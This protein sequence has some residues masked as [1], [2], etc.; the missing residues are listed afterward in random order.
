MMRCAHC[1]GLMDKCILGD[2]V[3]YRCEDCY[4]GDP[5]GCECDERQL[6]GADPTMCEHCE[7]VGWQSS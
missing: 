1:G 5:V 7:E 6:D 2:E 3:Y 4:Y